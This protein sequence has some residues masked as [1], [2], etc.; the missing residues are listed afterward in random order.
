MR[1]RLRRLR[2]VYFQWDVQYK[3]MF[4][5]K[6]DLEM[7]VLAECGHIIITFNLN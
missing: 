7:P 3:L 1:L 6:I 4:F 5:V 2:Y